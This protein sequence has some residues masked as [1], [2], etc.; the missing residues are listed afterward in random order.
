M[1]P[2]LLKTVLTELIAISKVHEDVKC[3]TVA[4]VERAGTVV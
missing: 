4:L 2:V 1:T 3:M